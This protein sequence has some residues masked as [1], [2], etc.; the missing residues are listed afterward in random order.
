MKVSS[1]LQFSQMIAPFEEAIVKEDNDA[2]K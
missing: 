1:A 2:L